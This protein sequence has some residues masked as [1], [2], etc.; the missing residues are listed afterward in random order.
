VSAANREG[1]TI[2]IAD[3]HRG[4]GKRLV[5]LADEKLAGVGDQS[6]GREVT[7]TAWSDD[8]CSKSFVEEIMCPSNQL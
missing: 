7:A 4:D 8:T 5:V 2:W 6:P 3:A 1:R